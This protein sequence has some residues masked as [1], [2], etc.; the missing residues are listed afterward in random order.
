MTTGFDGGDKAVERADRIKFFDTVR[1]VATV[2]VFMFHA[3]Y[4]LPLSAAS[5]INWTKLITDGG[6]VGVSIFFVLSGFLLFY[7]LFKT[8]APL[9]KARL[10][11]Y[12][13]KRLLRILPLYYFSLFFIA[14]VLNGDI[15]FSGSGLEAILYNLFFLRKIKSGGTGGALTINPV[16]WT[17]VVEMHFYI[18][19]PIFYH[20]FYKY[21]KITLF[22]LLALTGLAYRIFLVTFIDH[23]GMQLLRLT[24]ANFDYF[25]LG[26]LGAYLLVRRP[27]WLQSI[28]RSYLQVGALGLF[29]AL[30]YFYDFNFAPT[31]E[32]VFAP[33]LLG[34]IVVGIM[35]SFLVNSE[36]MIAKIVTTRPVIFIA[37][38]SFSIYV[39]H[40]IIIQ[41]VETLAL[42]NGFKFIIDVALTLAI[43][44]VSYYAIEW[45]FLRKKEKIVAQK[46]SA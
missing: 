4:L 5:A 28:G 24:P 34:I 25:A 39:W 43:A 35:L 32:Y 38:I 33:L 42:P 22:I 23:P 18:L 27:A 14:L 17:L 31:W 36:T 15:F 21:R 40:A 6:T 19:L 46:I 9:T 45:P 13:K 7:Q 2:A 12:V 10:K 16:Y 30:V 26:M 37:K 44:T 8:Q 41:R 1:A 20:I 29:F 3:G 11:E